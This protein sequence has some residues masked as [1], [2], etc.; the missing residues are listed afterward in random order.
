M[1]TNSADHG[2]GGKTSSRTL[3]LPVAKTPAGAAATSRT[4]PAPTTTSGDVISSKGP[5]ERR[6]YFHGQVDGRMIP[7]NR[8][9]PPRS[10]SSSSGSGNAGPQVQQPLLSSRRS[11]TDE[12]Y[13]ASHPELRDTLQRLFQELLLH[14]AAADQGSVPRRHPEADDASFKPIEHAI[15]FFKRL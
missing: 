4:K 1:A 9:P 3:L 2:R 11:Q 13:M 8:G 7:L 12:E 15:E 14:S 6:P 10:S 5:L